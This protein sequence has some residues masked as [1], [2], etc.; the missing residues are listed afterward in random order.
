MHDPKKIAVFIDGT[1][2]LYAQKELDWNFD[3][4]KVVALIARE[5]GGGIYNAFYYAVQQEDDSAQNGFFTAMTHLG[6]TVRKIPLKIG[7]GKDGE[8]HKYANPIEVQLTCDAIETINNYDVA[9]FMTGNGAYVRLIEHLRSHG[10]EI[11]ILSAERATSF[12]LINEADSFI[13]LATFREE[14]QK[15]RD[16]ADEHDSNGDENKSGMSDDEF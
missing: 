1:G 11:V 8:Q 16:R 9:V 14:L 10:K 12:A 3:F 15:T 5:L 6:L 2:I 7:K 4:R 13:S